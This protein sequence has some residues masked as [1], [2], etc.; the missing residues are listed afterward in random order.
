MVLKY[1]IYKF[2]FSNGFCLVSVYP[3]TKPIDV[4][5]TQPIVNLIDVNM[6]IILTL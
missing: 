6:L 1:L 4:R 3:N 2:D 5:F